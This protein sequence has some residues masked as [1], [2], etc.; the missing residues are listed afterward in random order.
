MH[1]PQQGC[2]C[3]GLSLPLQAV[4][5]ALFECHAAAPTYMCN[6]VSAGE[7]SRHECKHACMDD[8]ARNGAAMQYIGLSPSHMREPMHA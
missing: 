7:I 4:V 6:A 1:Q 3:S 8:G 2:R 5:R